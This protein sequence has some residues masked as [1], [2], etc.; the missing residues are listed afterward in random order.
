MA[1]GFEYASPTSV[2]DAVAR[3]RTNQDARVLAGGQRLLNQ[4]KAG[5]MSPGLLVDLGQ[6][7]GLTDISAAS[8]GRWR[9]GAMA[10]F[11]ALAGSDQLGGGDSA[12][13]DCI[14]QF[15]DAQVRNRATLGGALI[16]DHA[17]VDLP[18]VAL[19][20]GA[21]I[22]TAGPGGPGATVADAFLSRGLEPAQIVTAID[23]PVASARSASAYEKAKNPASSYAICGAAVAVT[24]AADGTVEACRV[25]ISG[26]A[27]PAVRLPKVEA[28]LLGQTASPAS[29]IRAAAH[30]ADEGVDFVD[31]VAAPAD[32][33]AHLAEVLVARALTR[34]TERARKAS[35]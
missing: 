19:A 15:G 13:A 31:D 18:A 5:R 23:W 20:L 26:A 24:L 34:A 2:E 28:A 25:A 17:G 27:A 6:V 11:D 8:G 4:M 3:L 10:T 14:R 1:T 35:V 9:T 32:Y 12:L 16:N 21:T 30:L 7:T 33:R 29:F 22:H